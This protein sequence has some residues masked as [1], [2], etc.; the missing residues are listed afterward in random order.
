MNVLIAKDRDSYL[1]DVCVTKLTLD[2]VNFLGYLVAL[3]VFYYNKRDIE[4]SFLTKALF[5]IPIFS[6]GTVA[7]V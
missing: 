6:F 1:Y 7:A 2:W 4:L 3:T 5:C